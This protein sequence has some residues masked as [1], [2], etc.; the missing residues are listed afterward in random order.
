MLGRRATTNSE[1]NTAG[2]ARSPPRS[3]ANA[4]ACGET[5]C[6]QQECDIGIAE[7]LHMLAILTQQACSAAVRVWPGVTHAANGCPKS[8][9]ATTTAAI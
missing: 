8:N 3:F 1:T 6:L 2:A 7:E 5:D 4:I 9:K